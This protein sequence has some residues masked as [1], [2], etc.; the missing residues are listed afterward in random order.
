MILVS[1]VTSG[2]MSSTVT[3]IPGRTSGSRNVIHD[4]Y[5]PGSVLKCDSVEHGNS[6]S[7]LSSCRTTAQVAYC[8]ATVS[9]LDDFAL[10]Y[11]MQEGSCRTSVRESIFS[12]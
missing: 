1:T 4:G 5:R 2:N 9:I 8:S 10:G 7:H 3:F 11:V 12:C 6:L